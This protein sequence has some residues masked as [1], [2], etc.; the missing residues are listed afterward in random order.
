MQ[1][2]ESIEVSQDR[3]TGRGTAITSGM[4]IVSSGPTC[5]TEDY[6][7][8][9]VLPRIQEE[10]TGDLAATSSLIGGRSESGSA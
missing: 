4:D 9:Y 6:H 1:N 5:I 7:I 3:L 8:L 10:A 2:E